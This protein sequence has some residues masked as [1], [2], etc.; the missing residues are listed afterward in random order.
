MKAIKIAAVDGEAIYDALRL[1]WDDFEDCVQFLA[2]RE[3]DSDYIITRDMD[4]FINSEI[5][6]IT[7][8]DFLNMLEH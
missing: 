7:P 3:L 8:T 5:P 4:G 2:A 1:R 6:P